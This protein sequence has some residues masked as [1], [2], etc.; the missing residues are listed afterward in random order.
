MLT[1]NT[2]LKKSGD[3]H[4]N[5]HIW[6]FGLTPGVTCVNCKINCYAKRGMY[7]TFAKVVGAHWEKNL[8]RSSHSSFTM[9]MYTEILHKPKITHIR[10]HPEGDFYSQEYLNK[11]ARIARLLP[12]RQFYAYTKALHLDFS[13]LP[14]N[15]KIIQSIGGEHDGIIDYTR[16]HAIVFKTE[17]DLIAAKY[18]NC[19]GDDMLAANPDTVLIGLIHH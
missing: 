13:S 17:V 9:E 14:S 18:I 7:R 5:T 2:K 11:W 16:P 4:S 19:S 3:G 1:Q 8:S 15:F 12:D 6:G 10:V